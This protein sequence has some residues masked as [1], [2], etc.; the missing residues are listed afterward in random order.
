MGLAPLPAR[1]HAVVLVSRLHG[2]TLRTLAYA[3]STR[4]STLHALTVQIDPE[5]SDQLRRDWHQTGLDVPLTVLDS[6][7]REITQPVVEYVRSLRRESPRDAVTVFIA[8][9]VAQRWWEHLL[10]NQSA[11]R[12]KTRLLFTPGVMVTS[13]P[14]QPEHT[15][16]DPRQATT[17]GL[18]R[19]VWLA[20]ARR[21]V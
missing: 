16:T 1:N 3:R 5:E 2:P 15:D 4:P 21:D 10:H 13:V 6:P 17:G 14:W 9:Y 20:A 18:R 12:I 8:E 11:L 7:Y 19:S